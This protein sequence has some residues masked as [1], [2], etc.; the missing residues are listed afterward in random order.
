LNA[1]DDPPRS[2]DVLGTVW[3]VFWS[4]ESGRL[5]RDQLIEVRNLEEP[6]RMSPHERA[7]CWGRA[8]FE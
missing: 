4:D 3:Q 2:G 6:A 8:E 5:W 1:A 7:A